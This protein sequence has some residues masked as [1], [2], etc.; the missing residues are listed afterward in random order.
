ML[1]E[2]YIDATIASYAYVF[3]RRHFIFT[4]AIFFFDFLYRDY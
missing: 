1:L 4:L 3:L 2:H